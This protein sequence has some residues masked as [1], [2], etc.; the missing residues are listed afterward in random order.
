MVDGAIW[1]QKD[2]ATILVMLRPMLPCTTERKKKEGLCTDHISPRYR[3]ASMDVQP[4][5]GSTVH[6]KTQHPMH[7]PEGRGEHSTLFLQMLCLTAIV[8][9]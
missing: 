7:L 8:G 1:Q 6:G 9:R 4:F 5:I 2:V 3:R